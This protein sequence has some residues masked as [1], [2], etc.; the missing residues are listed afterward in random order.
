MDTIPEEFLRAY[1]IYPGTKR[2]VYDYTRFVK[3]KDHADCLK[4]LVPAIRREIQW[5]MNCRK[6]GEFEPSWKMFS[7]W[8]N[9]RCWEQEFFDSRALNEVHGEMGGENRNALKM[10]ST[11]AICEGD[12][13]MHR[14][15]NDMRYALPCMCEKGALYE[16]GIPGLNKEAQKKWYE[17]GRLA[18]L[19]VKGQSKDVFYVVPKWDGEKYGYGFVDKYPGN[20][21][22]RKGGYLS[23]LDQLANNHNRSVH[24]R[25][26]R[27]KALHKNL[28]ER[29][30]KSHEE[31]TE[32]KG[33]EIEF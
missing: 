33:E 3:H 17:E 22:P 16:K 25:E 18:Y 4:L 21:I 31:M 29:D 30:A 8:I 6:K 23:A 15:V 5:K 9:Q 10:A 19:K 32:I 24:I 12:G 11:C 7:T 14:M 2:K 13:W 1:K 28:I 27:A 26:I 20:F